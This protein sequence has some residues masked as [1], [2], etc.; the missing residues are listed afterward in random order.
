MDDKT[1][2]TIEKRLARLEKTVFAVAGLTSRKVSPSSSRSGGSDFSGATGGIRFLTS[3]QFFKKKKTF[4]EV[5]TAMSSHDY[6]YSAQAAQ[7]ALNRLSRAGG[8][9][10]ALREGGKK[11]YAERK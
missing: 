3:K 10:V 6:N 1:L 9:L 5:R 4:S 8:P 2:K 7:T 11:L